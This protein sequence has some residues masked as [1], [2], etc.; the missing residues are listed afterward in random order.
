M[1]QHKS[2]L[3]PQKSLGAHTYVLCTVRV[4]LYWIFF[5]TT[6]IIYL[7]NSTRLTCVLWYQISL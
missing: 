3:R 7:C 6:T 5:L 4:I 2:P 1:L